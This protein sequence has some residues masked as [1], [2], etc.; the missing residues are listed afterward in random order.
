MKN[1]IFTLLLT[2]LVLN[3]LL[4][5]NQF[6]TIKGKIVDAQSKYPLS[7]ANITVIGTSLG[8]TS[9]ENGNFKISNV[10]YGRVMVKISFMG[11][12]EQILP[13]I[14]VVAG[15]E[16]DLTIE[17]IEK[18][19]VL[20]DV[21][22]SLSDEQLH[23]LNNE[24]ATVSAHSFNVADTRRFAG[25]RNDPARM[26]SSF[27]GVV[28]NSD[29]RNDII[30]RGNSPNG[31]LWRMEDIDIPNPNHFGTSG[32]TGGPVSMLNNN[33]LSKSDFMTGAFPAQYGNAISG[34]FDLRLRNGNAE[35]KEY[36]A[37]VGLN[38]FEFGAEGGIGQSGASYLFNYRYSALALLQ[39]IGLQFGTGTAIPFYQDLNFKLYFPFKNHSSLTVIGL[40]GK[41]S[42][43][44]DPSELSGSAVQT[45]ET[46]GVRNGSL[47]GVLGISYQHFYDKNT[48]GKLTLSF[49]KATEIT[50]TDSLNYLRKQ[51]FLAYQNDI[52]ISQKAIRYTLNRKFSVSN[53][54]SAGITYSNISF[55]FV[56]S[57]R[58]VNQTELFKTIHQTV[59]NTN[60]W[61]G[62]AQWEHRFSEKFT[63]N[64]GLFFQNY[65]INKNSIVIEPRFGVSYQLTENQLINF[66]FGLHGQS[67]NFQ[68]YLL[69]TKSKNGNLVQT[70]RDLGFSKSIHYVLSYTNQ[71]APSWRLKVEPYYQYLY[72]IPV[73]SAPSYYSALNEGA[74]YGLVLKD[75]LVNNGSGKNYGLELTL[76]KYF[77]KG[78]YFLWTTSLYQSKYKGSNDIEKNTAFNGNYVIN[79]LGGKEFKIADNKFLSFDLKTTLAGGRRYIPINAELSKA[80]QT[81]VYDYSKA[82]ENS[83]KD[84]SRF[85][86][87]ITYRV[88]LKKVSHEGYLDIQNVLNMQNIFSQNYNLRTD[89][90]VTQ[91]QFGFFPVL[92]YRVHF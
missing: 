53:V 26:A 7:G 45:T 38:G 23:S 79:F 56:D 81:T 15:K 28:G 82:Y 62:F 42:I 43:S 74:G 49:T 84:Y 72:S 50:E 21:K 58:F 41:S 13:N 20:N 80:N 47:T 17:L 77:G 37:Q 52:T 1:L 18:N 64:T 48:V 89:S 66:G 22:V 11:Y 78:F 69:E 46:I 27:A 67:Q 31:L 19:I 59:D 54:L 6:Q 25:S 33:V 4:A 3:N 61:Q 16:T 35:K 32:G 8:V 24:M 10:H 88:N 30:I 85:D 76:E 63:L 68:R 71:F 9:A 55:G 75:S 14:Q 39:K 36:M 70:N 73:Q 5:E 87:K 2:L 40:G 29:F 92:N 60:L 34:A 51:Y 44:I 57:V 65:R 86:V 90:V 91:Y 83:F 12:E